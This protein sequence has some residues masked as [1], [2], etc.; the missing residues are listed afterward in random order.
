[1]GHRRIQPYNTIF[2]GNLP[3]DLTEEDILALF[4]NRDGIIRSFIPKSRNRI[5][6]I[7]F[8]TFKTTE[9]CEEA[10]KQI[11][12]TV[13]RG[14][15][16]VCRWAV[17]R[18]SKDDPNQDV[19]VEYVSDESSDDDRYH[20]RRHERSRRKSSDRR[21][22]ERRSRRRDRR[23]YSDY[24]SSDDEYESKNGKQSQVSPAP[25][26]PMYMNQ[27]LMPPYNA[28]NMH[29]PPP[30]MPPN[31]PYMPPPPHPSGQAPP[32]QPGMPQPLQYPPPFQYPHPPPGTVPPNHPPP[33]G[34]VPLNQPPP[35][36]PPPLSQSSTPQQSLLQS[37]GF[38]A[39]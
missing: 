6:G 24:Y 32:Q 20:K 1:M 17:H 36:P 33:P 26:N 5:Q 37:S 18:K 10:I 30:P 21:R 39:K 23:D 12:N 16:V 27:L 14:R 7:G 11:H 38:L 35:P 19:S 9:M 3:F 13:I 29:H 4:K 22:R 28:Y 25:Y 2:V 34:A 8:I 15:T 31:Y